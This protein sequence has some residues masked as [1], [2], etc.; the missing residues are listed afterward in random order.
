MYAA[1]P[2]VVLIVVGAI[3]L[4]AVIGIMNWG[5]IFYNG[6]NRYSMTDEERSKYNMKRVTRTISSGGIIVMLGLLTA[7]EPSV[8]ET[9]G[10]Q[11]PWAGLVLFAASIVVFVAAYVAAVKGRYW[12]AE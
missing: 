3:V 11:D 1:T 12:R 6:F 8:L 9:F 2:V 5:H 4:F 10:I 7:V